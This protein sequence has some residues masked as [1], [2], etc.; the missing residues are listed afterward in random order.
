LLREI[1]RIFLTREM[2]D[3]QKA[4][5]HAQRLA[6][7]GS[8][9]ADVTH[10]L[11]NPLTFLQSNLRIIEETL[12][13]MQRELAAIRQSAED[14][15]RR[16]ASSALG[17]AMSDLSGLVADACTGADRIQTLIEDL[18]LFSR[19]PSER[20]ERFAVRDV[21]ESALSV[22]SAQLRRRARVVRTYEG[23]PAVMG[24]RARLAQVVLNLVLTTTRACPQ[25]QESQIH[26]AARQEGDRIVVEIGGPG[27]AAPEVTFGTNGDRPDLGLSICR[28]IVNGMGGTLEV[29]VTPGHSSV[30]RLRLPAAPPA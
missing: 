6:S 4:V 23:A 30:Y 3:P 25:G 1:E 19:S 2:R 9:A 20:R 14:A 13:Q 7:F 22:T 5:E 12:P 10:E 17:A 18:S 21:L 28:D 24:E 16:A 8:L 15:T 11:R 29:E 27:S 26:V